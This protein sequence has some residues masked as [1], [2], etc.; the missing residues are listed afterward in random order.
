MDAVFALGLK[1][2]L[3][4]VQQLIFLALADNADDNGLCWPGQRLVAQ[5]SGR[6]RRTVRRVLTQLLEAG[7]ISPASIPGRDY[8][9]YQLH[10]PTLGGGRQERPG[11]RQERPGGRQE[12]PGGRQETE[13]GRQ[14]RPEPP[15]PSSSNT[16]AQIPGT[17]DENGE[18]WAQG[19]EPLYGQGEYPS[20][21]EQLKALGVFDRSI[22][23][24]MD[25]PYWTQAYKRIEEFE[26]ARETGENLVERGLL[27]ESKVPDVGLLV[28][29]CLEGT[30]IEMPKPKKTR[31]RKKPDRRPPP[32]AKPPPKF[33]AEIL[34]WR[35]DTCGKKVE[36]T[37]AEIDFQGRGRCACGGMY[38]VVTQVETQ[39]SKV[40]N[41]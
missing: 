20:L 38:E 12:R 1:N 5:K 11:G 33:E 10:L 21:G 32:G 14:E 30:P 13:G 6:D 37:W 36:G 15:A 28:T 34:N 23:E 9:G 19:S 16:R 8:P 41:G 26:A 40:A 18:T 22:R 7:W 29:A 17:S 31:G 39:N 3:T 35:C 25:S 4:A 27:S 24:I 2:G